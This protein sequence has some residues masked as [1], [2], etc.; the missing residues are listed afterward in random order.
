MGKDDSNLP[1]DDLETATRLVEESSGFQFRQIGPYKILEQIGEGG[2]GVVYLAEQGQP[3]QRRVALKLIRLGMDSKQVVARFESERQALALMN[4]PNIARV[5][6]AG[7]TE[8]GL[9]YFVMELVQGVPI[10]QYCDRHRLSTEERLQL[11]AQVC[12]G[13]HHAHQKGIIHR[14]LKPSNIL[15][16]I[17]DGQPVPK[18][19]DF[20]VAKAIGRQLTEKTLFTEEGRLIGTPA[21]MSPE[22]AETTA[23][24]VDTRTD[25]YSLGVL[26]Y[27]LLVGEKPLDLRGLALIQVGILI[28]EKDPPTPSTRIDSL[29]DAGTEVAKRRRTSLTSLRKQLRG[30]LDWITMKALEK[31][32]TRRYTSTA[33]FGADIKRY[34]THQP[35]LASPPSTAYRARKFVQRHRLGVAAALAVIL[36]LVAG[37]I[38]A[39]VGLL[40]AIQA[41]E[42]ARQEAET[43]TQVSEF[44]VGLFEVSD[45]REARGNTITAREILDQGAERIE[46]EL[47]DQPVVRA[48]MM[49]AIGRV[50]RSLGLYEEAAPLLEESLDLRSGTQGENSLEVSESLNNLA[51]LYHFQGKYDEA[52]PHFLRSLAIVERV[53]GPEDPEVSTTLANLAALYND[54]GR[55]DESEPL[56]QRSLAIAEEAEDAEGL[57]VATSLNNLA[58]LYYAQGRYDEAEPLYE[59]SLALLEEEMGAEHPYVAVSLNN[60][61][62]LYYTQSKFAE[63]EPFFQRALT[64][65]EEVFGAEHP[66]VGQSL[67]NLAVLYR[68]M[69]RNSEAEPLLRRSLGIR[70]KALGPNH[71]DVGGSFHNLAALYAALGEY[72]E[73]ENHFQRSLAIFEE[74]L[75]AEHPNVS[76]SLNSLAE[77]YQKQGRCAE[78]EPLFRRSLAI[79]EK[80]LGPD[81]HYVAITL[82]SYALCLHQLNR[83]SEA[84]E[85]D[86]RAKAILNQSK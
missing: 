39:G 28:R 58:Q 24:D 42:R 9:P 50:Y 78:A 72:G 56:L 52:E 75:G 83:E 84:V 3:I 51:Q 76:H 2:M 67:N 10:T 15:V 57:D 33:E 17:Q 23:L 53:K 62:Q 35:V 21:Y 27:E 74:A 71:P 26:L 37:A 13:V 43:A 40:R 6:D 44:L 31:D 82:E 49:D 12:E 41:E 63:A 80:A 45:P 85:M 54:Q 81:H 7:S 68:K 18:I 22:Q 60:L 5:H 48:R 70:E 19:I 36:A 61:G 29:A 77:V 46:S 32:R 38:G 20:G 4:H 79:R 11:F 55:Y 8:Q 34:L 59:R 65:R 47:Q 69:D 16:T 66:D 25:V 86:A 73:A 64:I 30:E 14:D 1:P